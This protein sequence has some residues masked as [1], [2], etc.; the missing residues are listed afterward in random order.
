MTLR[1]YQ[2]LFFQFLNFTALVIAQGDD[3]CTTDADA[4]Y[5]SAD[6]T[7]FLGTSF[8]KWTNCTTTG[9]GMSN[10]KAWINGGYDDAHKIVS[11]DGTYQN[12]Q[13][14]KDAAL[15]DFFG[16]SAMISSDVRGQIQS[17]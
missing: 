2:F 6:N 7:A 4:C 3:D 1:L 11:V 14:T 8:T 13:W 9:S 10:Q 16:P 15:D 17:K 12:I 5:P